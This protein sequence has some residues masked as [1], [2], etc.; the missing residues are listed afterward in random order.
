MTDAPRGA[1]KIYHSD[2]VCCEGERVK[3]N[4]RVSRDAD[5][6]EQR[7]L[8][9]VSMTLTGHHSHKLHHFFRG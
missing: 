7:T 8:S 3:T 6:C 2:Y 9:Y 4:T 5:I 1:P